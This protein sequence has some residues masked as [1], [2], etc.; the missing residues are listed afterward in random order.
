VRDQVGNRLGLGFKELGAVNFKNIARPIE[1]FLLELTPS[2]SLPPLVAPGWPRRRL[3]PM[4]GAVFICVVAV[5]G[6]FGLARM[7]SRSNAPQSPAVEAPLANNN[8]PPLSIAVLP[9]ENLS[10]HSD[11]EMMAA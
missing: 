6:I 3:V 2:A 7:Q 8:L 1:A 11:D 5:V 9:F 4:L 10:G